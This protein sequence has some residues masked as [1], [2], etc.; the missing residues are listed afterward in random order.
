MQKMQDVTTTHQYDGN[1]SIQGTSFDGIVVAR[2]Y[3]SRITQLSI[4]QYGISASDELRNAFFLERC[5]PLPTILAG[6]QQGKGFA[7]QIQAGFQP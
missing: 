5:D 4:G 1:A 3:C 6:R 2:H 7:L